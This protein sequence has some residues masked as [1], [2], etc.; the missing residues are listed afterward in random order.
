MTHVSTHVDNSTQV[1][2]TPSE[3]STVDGSR[4]H[5]LLPA[6]TEAAH[7]HGLEPA[8]IAAIC[9]AESHLTPSTYR[10][11]TAYWAK[12]CAQVPKYAGKDPHRVG[13]AYGLMQLRFPIAETLGYSGPPE[14][15]CVP[16]IALHYGCA[17]LARLLR[18]LKTLDQALAA[19]HAG[20]AD[21]D[22]PEGRA[23]AARIRQIAATVPLASN[24]VP[25]R[26]S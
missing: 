11:D 21:A 18:A 23:Y 26:K 4:L 14:M 7:R 15:L 10:F 8:V 9:E 12:Y 1:C 25:F 5:F 19:F 3:A 16:E 6:I 17:Y 13:G 2:Y 20:P 24:V 22:T